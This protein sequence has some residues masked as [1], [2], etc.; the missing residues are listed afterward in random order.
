MQKEELVCAHLERP[1]AALTG[2]SDPI[3]LSASAYTKEEDHLAQECKAQDILPDK[4][5]ACL[6][7]GCGPGVIDL[8]GSKSAL[9]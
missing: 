4:E 7:R 2:P 9:H 1:E 5:Q 8:K 6:A 3:L